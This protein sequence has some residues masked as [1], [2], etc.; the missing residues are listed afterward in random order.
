MALSVSRFSFLV[1]GLFRVQEN[2]KQ[3]TRNPKPIPEQSGIEYIPTY[4]FIHTG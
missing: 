4:S 1:S 3:E 2:Q